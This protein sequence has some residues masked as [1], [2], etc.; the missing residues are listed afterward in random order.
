MKF[1][2]EGV[3]YLIEFERSHRVLQRQV[4]DQYGVEKVNRIDSKFPYTTA[5][6]FKVTGPGKTDR[7]LVREYT[8][9]CAVSDNYSLDGGRKAALA[10]ALYDAPT[11]DGGPS[12]MAS[13]VLTKEFRTAVWNAY[14]SRSDKYTG[15]INKGE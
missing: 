14:H 13:S 5:R 9:G 12:V 1:D 8:V 3:S 7:E 10:M 11:K 2:Y 15:R 4:V 6:L